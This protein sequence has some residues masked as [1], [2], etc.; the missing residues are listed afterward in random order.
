MS[1]FRRKKAEVVEPEPDEEA[2]AREAALREEEEAEQQLAARAAA[3]EKLRQRQGPK[4]SAEVEDEEIERI[5]LGALRF[6]PQENLELRMEVV[7]EDQTVRSVTAVLGQSQA[8]IQVF[9][10]PRTAGIWDDIRADLLGEIERQGGTA[11]E[12]RGTF[13]E[14][15]LAKLSA[16][17]QGGKVVQHQ[18][19][20]IGVDGP[21]WFL[22]AVI[23][24]PAA[25]DEKARA[26][27]EDAIK[28]AV[29]HRGPEALPP[30]ELLT[31]HLPAGAQRRPEPDPELNGGRIPTAPPERGPEIT[32]IR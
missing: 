31:M 11:Q 7:Q 18:T 22:R 17:G 24:G 2:L 4:D 9:A 27:L 26:P 16:P 3:S 19:L 28:N 25:A 10:A 30:R 5:D 6:A 32:E 1:L 14:E 13:G 29:V 21:R 8:Q 12:R 20:F 15:I 23:S